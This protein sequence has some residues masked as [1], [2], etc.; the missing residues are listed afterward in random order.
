MK[1]PKSSRSNAHLGLYGKLGA[2]VTLPRCD[3]APDTF[4]QP[5]P[6]PLGG[7]ASGLC[8]NTL[9]PECLWSAKPVA[10]GPGS[11]CAPPPENGGHVWTWVMCE[12]LVLGILFMDPRKRCTCVGM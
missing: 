7:C 1:P 4:F 10:P 5:V 8:P 9:R 2:K 6:L 3:T 12:A 11:M